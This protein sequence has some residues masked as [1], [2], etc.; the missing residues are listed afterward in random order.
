MALNELI[1]GSFEV[2]GFSMDYYKMKIMNRP[3]DFIPYVEFEDQEV[4]YS[5]NPSESSKGRL[6]SGLMTLKIIN[7]SK[8]ES[9]K[10]INRQG[11]YNRILGGYYDFRFSFRPGIIYRCRVNSAPKIEKMKAAGLAY[12]IYTVE[13][14]IQPIK[15]L[16]EPVITT[17]TSGVGF[18]VVCDTPLDL[19]NEPLI[20]FIGVTG[21]PD[22]TLT[23]DNV[24]Y[25][26][27]TTTSLV[28]EDLIIDCAN[29]L[30][31]AVDRSK[32]MRIDYNCSKGYP[33]L[34]NGSHNV[35]ITADV[36]AIYFNKN[37]VIL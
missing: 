21:T 4:A 29:K 6:V 3:E 30:V 14:K 5:N 25:V 9:E 26:F 22:L 13:L 31:Y 24:D 18:N 16:A 19:Y 37:E 11:F 8:N 34:N 23:I 36:A 17:V 27:K 12:E 20:T 10:E 1:K 32:R 33:R 35:V 28:N 15:R 7:S 2:D